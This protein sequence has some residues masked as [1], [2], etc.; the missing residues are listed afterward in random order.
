MNK[1]TS[2]GGK[3]GPAKVRIGIVQMRMGEN[4]EENLVTALEGTGEAAE[5]GAEIVCL[6][7]LFAW[8][9]FPTA[10]VSHQMPETI[11]GR[12]SKALSDSARR[13]QVVL[14]GGSIYEK[15]GRSNYNT[16]LVFD[17]RGKTVS[18]YR[19]VHIPQDE[20]YYEQDYFEPGTKYPVARTR[21]GTV[22]TLICFD[23]WYPEAA[24]ISKLLGAEMLFY[25][26]AIGWV[27]GIDPVEGDWKKAWESV[28]V[29]HAIANSL[30]VC[31]VNRVG[32][33]GTT[34]FWGGS[35]VCDQFGKILFSAGDGEG[36]FTVDCDLRLGRMVEEGWGFMKNRKKETYSAISR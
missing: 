35:F 19:K 26:T 23:Q 15:S 1:Q 13:N 24:R 17:E 11:P 20:H 9:Y 27:K 14:V 18:K 22:G 6:P 16:C 4:V 5:K 32:T 34:T 36:V 10:R 31:A 12:V 2:S 30:V 21:A 8:R 28:Q 25:P 3:S 7:E 29:G 33:E